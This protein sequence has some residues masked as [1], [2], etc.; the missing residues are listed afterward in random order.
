MTNH[1]IRVLL[2]EG[3]DDDALQLEGLLHAI[4]GLEVDAKRCKNLKEARSEVSADTFDLIL[5][6]LEQAEGRGLAILQK[7][8]DA[9]KELLPVIATSA[10][11]DLQLGEEILK[12]GAID[13]LPKDNYTAQNVAQAVRFGLQRWRQVVEAEKARSSLKSFAHA[14]AHDLRSPVHSIHSFAEMLEAEISGSHLSADAKE[15]LDF[16]KSSSAHTLKLI[17]GLLD[18]SL[19]GNQAV[20][21][22]RAPLGRAASEVVQNMTATI[23]KRHATVA[24]DELPEAM[25]D[26][27]LVGHVLQNL[28]G[29]GIKY[30][31]RENPSIRISA[32]EGARWVTVTVTDNGMG[33]DEKFRERIFEPFKRLH[34]YN[35]IEGTGLGL[36]ICK[37]IID[38]HGGRIWV[39]SAPGGGSSF[40]FTL[41]TCPKLS[42]P[43]PTVQAEKAT[44][45]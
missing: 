16:I 1:P 3:D 18:F 21:L 35:E 28:I 11:N 37:R 42:S 34:A 26:Y 2:V 9:T 44:R 24:I 25:A 31:Q 12:R 20:Y 23:E 8:Q 39:E 30:N 5:L 6:N 32:E 22:D 4:V 43:A 17:S 29:N 40:R 10:H 41:P 38:G 13:F 14:A 45:D 15:Y 27:Q 19:I 36:A 7:L 33:I